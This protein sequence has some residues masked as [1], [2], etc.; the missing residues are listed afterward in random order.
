MDK[1]AG[2]TKAKYGCLRIFNI[3]LTIPFPNPFIFVLSQI[4]GMKTISVIFILSFWITGL[5]MPSYMVL[6]YEEND[7]HSALEKH[8]EEQ[9]ESEEK[10]SL[11]I[12]FI[13]PLAQLAKLVSLR[14]LDHALNKDTTDIREFAVEI[15]LP[16]PEHLV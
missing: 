14:D 15:I 4:V 6:A 16:P 7:I 5:V 1:K 9:Q 11:E 13:F 3:S 10:D 12:E 8:E 2:Y